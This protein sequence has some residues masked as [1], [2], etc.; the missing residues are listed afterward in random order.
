M[1]TTVTDR[2]SC[3]G[4]GLR[5]PPHDGLS[6]HRVNASPACLQVYAEVVGFA[7]Q[8]LTLMKWHQLTV[9]VYG[10]QHGGGKAPPIRLAYSLV[11][12]HLAVDRDLAGDEVRAA[13]QR[14]GQPDPSWPAFIPP[15]DP[16]WPTVMTVA[17][18]GVMVDSVA[19]H[20]AAVHGWAEEV[21]HAW[22]HQH[23]DVISL[24]RRLLPDIVSG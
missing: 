23:E 14:M 20:D 10:G 22:R 18:R 2:T 4:C 24:T 7:Y 9:D 17:E 21:W 8:H 11:G 5:L 6:D 1:I 15:Q 16:E 12:L 3:P 13:H 19:G